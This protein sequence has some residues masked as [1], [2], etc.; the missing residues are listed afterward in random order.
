[1]KATETIAINRG[2][3]NHSNAAPLM[4]AAMKTN[5]AA[6]GAARDDP[7]IPGSDGPNAVAHPTIK[8]QYRC[9]AMRRA[10]RG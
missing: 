6:D 1:M 4:E 8:G 2:N 10:K 9:E 3:E 7:S 5:R